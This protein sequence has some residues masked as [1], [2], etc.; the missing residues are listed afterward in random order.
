MGG[1]CDMWSGL[2]ILFSI[3]GLALFRLL[4][5]PITDLG[6][7]WSR[8]MESMEC[9]AVECNGMESMECIA[10]E[11]NGMDAFWVMLGRVAHFGSFVVII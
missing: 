8:W 11:W 6:M 2:N 7:E 10:V 3:F 5:A 9:I 4:S 1:T